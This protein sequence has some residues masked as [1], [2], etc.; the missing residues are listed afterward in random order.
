M[1]SF[2]V[3]NHLCT[4]NLDFTE[5]SMLSTND[6]KNYSVVFN[7]VFATTVSGSVIVTLNSKLLKAKM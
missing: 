7:T 4:V 2:F 6:S 1:G 3:H 5:F